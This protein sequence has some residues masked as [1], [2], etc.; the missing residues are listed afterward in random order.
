MGMYANASPFTSTQ[1]F[2]SGRNELLQ[3]TLVIAH[4]K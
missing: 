3:L 2:T 1:P 4:K